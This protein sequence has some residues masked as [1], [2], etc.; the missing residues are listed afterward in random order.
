MRAQMKVAD[1]SGAAL[2]VIVGERER[3]DGVVGLRNL[4]G[5]VTEGDGAQER[6]PREALIDVLRERLAAPARPTTNE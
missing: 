6:V 2:A 1:R 4:R 3:A 5:A